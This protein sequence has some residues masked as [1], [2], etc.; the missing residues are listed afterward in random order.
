MYSYVG[1]LCS[2]YHFIIKNYIHDKKVA[3][4]ATLGNGHDTDFLSENFDKVYAFDIQKSAVDN[5]KANNKENVILINDSHSKFSDYISEAVQCIVYNLG[6][7]P[8]GDKSITT[9]ASTSLDSIRMG[10]EMLNPGGY[11]FIACYVG[12]DEGKRE[13]SCINDFLN[14]LPTKK[15]GV[16]EQ[17][18][19]NRHNNPPKLFIIEKNS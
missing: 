12:H 8:G 16:M 7:L 2:I 6:F 9:S 14:N 18:Y 3:V 19:I 11:M 15:Y 10:L 1:D 5:Y 4:D 13:Y 17:C